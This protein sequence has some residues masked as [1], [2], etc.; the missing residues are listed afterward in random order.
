MP[1]NVYTD[2]PE[3]GLFFEPTF[4]IKIHEHDEY[5]SYKF[6]ISAA[7][8]IIS[9]GKTMSNICSG[10]RFDFDFHDIY[11]N[12]Y[13]PE[14]NIPEDSINEFKREIKYNTIL[15]NNI[16]EFNANE[17]ETAEC[18]IL[19]KMARNFNKLNRELNRL[20]KLDFSNL[21]TSINYDIIIT[22]IKN[23][24][25]KFDKKQHSYA[26]DTSKE[27]WNEIN[28]YVKINFYRD[29]IYV[30][31]TIQIPIFESIL[32]HELYK[33]P[34]ILNDVPYLLNSNKKYG[35]FL[36]NRVTFLN[37]D[38]LIKDC[39]FVHEE[40][41][42][43]EPKYNS[44]CETE[45]FFYGRNQTCLTRL[46]KK[47]LITR[48][49]TILY[50][51]VFKPMIFTIDCD[52]GKHMIRL[53][54]HSKITND[55]KCTVN[56]SQFSYNPKILLEDKYNLFVIEHNTN[57]ELFDMTPLNLMEFYLTLSYVI[58]IVIIYIITICTSICK[59]KK[60]IKMS[61]QDMGSTQSISTNSLHLYE[62]VNP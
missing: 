40:Y 4:K 29:E 6:D 15:N 52:I 34:I 8:Y 37:E 23:T 61:K 5:L 12:K 7:N 1:I 32:L 17:N 60:K 59:L 3:N 13:N 18:E 57:T 27:T 25:A 51:S 24:V 30:I 46:P 19:G 22:D 54:E 21:N 58:I 20:A 56:T 31:L 14:P 16:E 50:V 45:I 43:T 33:K 9:W 26:I 55:L 28:K 42:C 35:F 39:L 53:D 10:N 48:I 38:Y 62:T 36:K 47:N 11:W 2:N 44:P 41:Y 49:N